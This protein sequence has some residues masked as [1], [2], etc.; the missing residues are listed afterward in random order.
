MKKK[1]LAFILFLSLFL[2]CH[3]TEK[4]NS[5]KINHK[6]IKKTAKIVAYSILA[7]GAATTGVASAYIAKNIIEWPRSGFIPKIIV[8]LL[9]HG[10]IKYATLVTSGGSVASLYLAWHF[11]KNAYD[12]AIKK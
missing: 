12:L 6:N 10:T 7:A 1:K 3:A 2:C 4:E 8:K 5:K 11:A 9:P